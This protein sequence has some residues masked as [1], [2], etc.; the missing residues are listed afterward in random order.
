[1]WQTAQATRYLAHNSRASHL[2]E[3]QAAQ[4]EYNE[5]GLHEDSSFMS[6]DDIRFFN[7]Y[8]PSASLLFQLQQGHDR[9]LQ[10][11]MQDA[12]SIG[13]LL[14]LHQLRVLPAECGADMLSKMVQPVLLMC[15]TTFAPASVM[16]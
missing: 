7:M 8:S 12:L 15:T 13:T 11:R 5:K 9:A 4:I 16:K 1:M 2:S 6:W 3:G 10:W 14:Q